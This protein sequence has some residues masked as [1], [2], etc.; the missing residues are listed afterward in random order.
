[1][2]RG[3]F[4]LIDEPWICLLSKNG[5][6]TKEGLRKVF[7][8]AQDFQDLGGEIRLQD[9]AVLRL[10]I[11]ISVTILYRYDEKGNKAE[12]KDWYHALERFEAVWRTGCFSEKAVNDYFNKWYERFYLFDEK[13]PFYQIRMDAVKWENDKKYPEGLKPVLDNGVYMNWLP[14][15]AI[16]G[17]VLKSDNRPEVPYKDIFGTTVDEVN[18]D[19]AAR[20]LIFYNGYADCTV[21][22]KQ[23]FMDSSGKKQSANAAMTLPSRG[24]LITAVGRNLFETIVINSVLYTPKRRKLYTSVRPFWEEERS[25]PTISSN[26][27]MPHDLARMY[28][29]QSRQMFLIRKGQTVIGAFVSA[30]ESYLAEELWM[31]PAFMMQNIKAKGSNSFIQSPVCCRNGADI[32]REIEHVAGEDGAGITQW[33][34]ELQDYAEERDSFFVENV[35]PFRVT[36]IRYG[37]SSCSIQMMI[38]DQ[39][40]LSRQFLVDSELRN[41]SV[42]E[43]K[44]IEQ[45]AKIINSFGNNCAKCMGFSDRDTRFGKRL[46]D[47]YYNVI[48]LAFRRFLSGESD[49]QNLRKLEVD[50][51]RETTKQFIAHNIAS[52]LRG[53]AGKTQMF[54]GKAEAIFNTRLLKFEERKNG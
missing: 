2:S 28:T 51:A 7:L 43:L 48:G 40:L 23:Y 1:M 49:I 9:M 54:L 8:K 19:E 47:Q 6:I 5:H 50:V 3:E 16:N 39:I 27:P 42:Y 41:D 15:A 46:T 29:Q 44:Q 11:A 38:E 13:Y 52:L 32:W 17:R 21:G 25:K 53:K 18:F 14:I 26:K 34:K 35:I 33:I 22:K 4:N 36:G 10:L 45:I 12:L 31:E 37:A 24:A 20:W 30:G